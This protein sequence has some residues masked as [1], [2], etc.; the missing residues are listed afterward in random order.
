MSYRIGA[1][2]DAVLCVGVSRLFQTQLLEFIKEARQQAKNDRSSAAAVDVTGT[3]I[4][5]QAH[6][7]TIQGFRAKVSDLLRDGCTRIFLC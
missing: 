4:H 2:S 3:A 5:T 1:S 7:E 6:R